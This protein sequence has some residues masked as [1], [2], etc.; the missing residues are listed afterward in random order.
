MRQQLKKLEE[1]NTDNSLR[2]I[3]LIGKDGDTSDLVRIRS[4]ETAR[5]YLREASN[6]DEASNALWKAAEETLD[7]RKKGPGKRETH[8]EIKAIL[9]ERQRAVNEYNQQEIRRRTH[10]LKITSKQIRAK[11]IIDSLEEGKWDPVK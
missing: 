11:W 1:E 9:D 7:T 5:I 6:M 8:P 2:C 3:K 4:L 10:K